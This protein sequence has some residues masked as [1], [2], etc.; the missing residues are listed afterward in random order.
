MI[1]KKIKRLIFLLLLPIFFLLTSCYI[2]FGDTG[3]TEV[4]SYLHGDWNVHSRIGITDDTLQSIS[5]DQY[6]I[7]LNY[8]SIS[9]NVYEEYLNSGG[10]VYDD[11]DNKRFFLFYTDN[12]SYDAKMFEIENGDLIYYPKSDD[13]TNYYVLKEE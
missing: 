1:M 2:S 8:V 12:Y 6:S 11:M 9:I 4:P 3:N 10:R 7:T 5:I 13:Q